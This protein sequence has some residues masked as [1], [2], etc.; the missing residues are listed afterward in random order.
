MSQG[1][2]AVLTLVGNAA[3]L[4]IGVLDGRFPLQSLLVAG[5]TAS[6]A[7]AALFFLLA[8]RALRAREPPAP[9]APV[10]GH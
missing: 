1:M 5:V 4:V 10:P 9:P 2:I 6:Y 7:V 3:P 8:A